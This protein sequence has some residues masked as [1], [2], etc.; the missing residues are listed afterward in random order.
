MH[1]NKWLLFSEKPILILLGVLYSLPEH[2]SIFNKLKLCFPM[3]PTDTLFC[4]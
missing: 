1:F 4:I 2:L 3:T